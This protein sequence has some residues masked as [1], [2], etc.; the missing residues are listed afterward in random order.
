[1]QGG[2]GPV[3]RE[4][5]DFIICQIIKFAFW[6]N[7]QFAIYIANWTFSQN[8][9]FIISGTSGPFLGPFWAQVKYSAPLPPGVAPGEVPVGGGQVFLRPPPAP[10]PGPRGRLRGP[11]GAPEVAHLC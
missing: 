3:S 10:G 4:N 11:P 1:M 2:G 5:A 6:E 9:D 8:A 7:V